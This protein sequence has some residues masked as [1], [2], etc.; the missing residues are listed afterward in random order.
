MYNKTVQELN[1][2]TQTF[3]SVLNNFVAELRAENDKQ[4]GII[5]EAHAKIME[6]NTAQQAVADVVDNAINALT[7]VSDLVETHISESEV[8]AE[9][10][11]DVFFTL[12]TL[13]DEDDEESEDEEDE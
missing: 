3:V 4:V 11:D 8:V 2:A 7:D 9:G 6:V 13:A 5:R 12:D 10:I 1:N